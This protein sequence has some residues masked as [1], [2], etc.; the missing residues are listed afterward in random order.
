M[1]RHRHSTQSCIARSSA[2]TYLQS[3]QNKSNKA[4]KTGR[5]LSI[6]GTPVT[7]DAN[8]NTT[9]YTVRG[10]RK[11]LIYDAEN[12]PIEVR[13]IDPVTGAATAS[14]ARY[15][16]GP[17]GERIRKL[18]GN[19]YLATHY[20]GSDVE[21]ETGA[22]GTTSFTHYLHADVQRVAG[23][24]RWLHKDHLSSNR[25]ITNATGSVLQRLAYSPYGKPTVQAPAASKAYINER[26]DHETG[27]SYL[28]ARYLDSDLGRFL[29]PD[30]WDPILAGVDTNR[31]AYAGNDPI[32]FS[33]PNGHAIADVFRP[34]EEETWRERER[35]SIR[36]ILGDIPD[37]DAHIDNK[38]RTL[39]RAEVTTPT[40]YGE[41]SI[42]KLGKILQVARTAPIAT[43]TAASKLGLHINVHG[44]LQRTSA[45]AEGLAH[46]VALFAGANKYIGKV[47]AANV[48]DVYFHVQ[49]RVINPALKATSVANN[50]IDVVV[51]MKDGSYHLVEY[52][53]KSQTS[54][55]A[56]AKL[57]KKL[58]DTASALR[59]AGH[60]VTTDLVEY[61]GSGGVKE[62][63]KKSCGNFQGGC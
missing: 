53:S 36:S 46:Q 22:T 26:Y 61:G 4:A 31:Y 24:L 18:S 45:T 63:A 37:I 59:E 50:Q 34:D 52:A 42:L 23:A 17:D 10:V 54:R 56:L 40:L 15:A 30:T 33:D 49:N 51:R 38:N 47:G 28:H 3:Y 11:R 27:L 21:I 25:L 20:L 48:T 8:G 41:A 55:N 43:G 58:N 62:A 29:S 60:K 2:K 39:A 35:S 12:R 9:E 5:I 16:Y 19:G 57:E 6:C 14:L 13:E 1:S 44:V 32:N 7:Y